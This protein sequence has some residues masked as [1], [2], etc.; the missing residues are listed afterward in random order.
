M[1]AGVVQAFTEEQVARLTDIAVGRLRY[2]DRTNFFRPEYAYENRRDA[3]SRIYSYLDLVSLKVIARLRKEGASLQ[4]LRLVKPKL[5]EINSD[6]WRGLTLWVYG[7]KVAFLHPETGKP[8]EVGSGQRLMTFA[9]SEEIDDLDEKV[10]ALRRR[11]AAKIGT[12]ERHR[13]VMHNLPVIGGTRIPVSAIRSF[14]EEGYTTERIIAEYPSL[15][16]R[17]I[18][19]ALADDRAA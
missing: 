12:I 9:L 19:A 2:W 11:D 5:A 1:S 13:R 8:E 4:Q 16:P 6:L 3:Y 10:L 18:E 7:G 14:H 15:T 17:D